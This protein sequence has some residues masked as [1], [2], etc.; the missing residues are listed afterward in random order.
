MSERQG[1][2]ASQ[3]QMQRQNEVGIFCVGLGRLE[4]HQSRSEHCFMIKMPL[5]VR[6]DHIFVEGLEL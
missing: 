5:F 3:R 4:F 1:L 6:F 2:L